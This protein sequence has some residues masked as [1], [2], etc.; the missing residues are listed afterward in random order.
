MK[1]YRSLFENYNEAI[2]KKCEES[3][4]SVKNRDDYI[5][6]IKN[7]RMGWEEKEFKGSKPA[8][9]FENINDREIVD[10]FMIAAEVCDDFI[11]ESF[12]NV[13]ISTENL[14][15]VWS[16]AFQKNE[17]NPVICAIKIAGMSA[18]EE[19]IKKL[20]EL[21]YKEGEY[22]DLIKET[23]RQALVD[24]GSPA[25]IEIEK[26]L[27]EKD[28]YSDDDF[29]LIIAIIEI[30]SN[31]KS[32]TTY[33]LLKESFRKTANKGLAA[34]CIADYG[35]GRAVPMLR[36]YLEK[37]IEKLDKNTTLDIQGAI[38]ALGGNTD[39]LH[40]PY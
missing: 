20:I 35:D 21:I 13:I 40:V 2:M 19:Y 10:V 14:R 27:K 29:H 33:S 11:P 26:K 36:G 16:A 30:D 12:A 38:I 8:E 6:L 15:S 4:E 22:G 31:R 24:I 7:A 9:I 32:E 23:A 17:I 37:N 25:L 39:D 34:R 3:M 28:I 18:N 1:Q 5:N